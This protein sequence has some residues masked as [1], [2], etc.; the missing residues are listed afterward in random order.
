MAVSDGIDFG[1]EAGV[2]TP[3]YAA[4]GLPEEWN[5]VGFSL[6][7]VGLFGLDGDAVTAEID[8]FFGTNI[9]PSSVTG[10]THDALLQ[11]HATGGT[12]T[13]CLELMELRFLNPG[14]YRF[15]I[16]G[17]GSRSTFTFRPNASEGFCVQEFFV[18]GQPPWPGGLV[19]GR[20]H[21]I[22]ETRITESG[23]IGICNTAGFGHPQGKVNG[24]QVIATCGNGILD[25]NEQ[26]DDGNTAEHD[27]CTAICILPCGDGITRDDEQCDDGNTTDG[28]GCGASCRLEFCGDGIAN[29]VTE[30]CD[31]G[32]SS[33]YYFVL[34]S[35][36][37]EYPPVATS[38]R[39]DTDHQPR[40]ACDVEQAAHHSLASI[41]VPHSGQ[42]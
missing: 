42:V 3:D 28:D 21:I 13:C 8:G 2:P 36:Q 20:T 31:D 14:P 35:E 5:S 4:A 6:T 41:G 39:H 19:E 34:G 23:V 9:L 38:P 7:P 27:G 1:E 25:A 32:N 16:Y 33:S 12:D 29:N 26:C 40:D 11:D 18:V 17:Y 30:Q 15:I 37:F 22:Y 24:I 10:T